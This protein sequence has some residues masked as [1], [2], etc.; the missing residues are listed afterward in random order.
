MSN[1]RICWLTPEVC[2]GLGS[3]A[4]SHDPARCVRLLPS[5]LLN[6]NLTPSLQALQTL[7]TGRHYTLA[8]SFLKD[9][10]LSP[11]SLLSGAR[12]VLYGACR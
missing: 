4:H 10:L 1:H 8:A 6:C 7:L 5:V 9:M 2:F 11:T 12:Q 3:D